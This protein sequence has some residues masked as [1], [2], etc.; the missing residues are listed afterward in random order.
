MN[1]TQKINALYKMAQGQQVELSPKDKI[2][3]M[4]YR[5][6]DTSDFFLTKNNIAEYVDA[7]DKGCVL[8]FDM[9]CRNHH[10]ADR[11]RKG[12]SEKDMAATNR[13]ST[14]AVMM[15]GWLTWGMA[16]YSLIGGRSGNVGGCAIMGLIIAAILS[17]V[18][19]YSVIFPFIILAVKESG[20]QISLVHVMV[21]IAIVA[22]FKFSKLFPKLGS[23]ILLIAFFVGAY[24]FSH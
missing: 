15:F 5:I 24:I 14:V 23:I 21:L 17:R 22:Y 19:P 2:G 12:S 20:F 8:S 10:K 1:K 11:R 7:V 9:W 16:I 13:Y 18:T 6:D 3:L 4:K